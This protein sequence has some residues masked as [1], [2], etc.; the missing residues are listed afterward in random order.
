MKLFSFWRSLATWP[1]S[2]RGPGA[3][4]SVTGATPKPSGMR[5]YHSHAMAMTDLTRSTYSGEFGFL[6][7]EPAAGDPGRYDR[8]FCSPRAT[9]KA[10]GSACRTYTRDRRRITGSR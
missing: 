5:W 7:I 9:G 4:S 3:S 6:L 10:P 1:L 8:E 2:T